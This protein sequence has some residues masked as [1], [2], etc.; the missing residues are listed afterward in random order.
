MST[1]YEPMIDLMPDFVDQVLS[2]LARVSTVYEPMI[3][4]TPDLV[5]QVLSDLAYG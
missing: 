5:D 4:L 3:D 1:V 2:D